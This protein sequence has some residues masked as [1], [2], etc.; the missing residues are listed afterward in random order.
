MCDADDISLE[1]YEGDLDS[2]EN[3]FNEVNLN[4]SIKMKDGGPKK[5][6]YA[7]DFHTHTIYSDGKMSRE[8]NNDMAIKQGLD[9]FVPL[10]LHMAKA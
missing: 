5:T 1:I 8:A 9:F 6:S 10:S 2:E 4:D 3:S 7:A